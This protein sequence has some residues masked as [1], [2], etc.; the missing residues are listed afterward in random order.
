LSAADTDEELGQKTVAILKEYNMI[1]V[2]MMPPA[3]PS[4]GNQRSRNASSRAFSSLPD[5]KFDRWLIDAQRAR[6]A[7][8]GWAKR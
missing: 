3:R 4:N 2:S 8:A 1:A 6:G 5:Q 7:F